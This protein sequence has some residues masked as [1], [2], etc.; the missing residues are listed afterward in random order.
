[1]RSSS[2]LVLSLLCVTMTVKAQFHNIKN[3]VFWNTKDNRPINSQG[4]GIFKFVDPVSG[5]Q[6]YYWYGVYYE[7][8][9]I[10]R[11]DP[12]ITLSKCTF[13]SVTCYSSVDLV[14][15]TFEADAV[16]KDEV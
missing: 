10:Y 4:G 13:K 16:K 2:F 1:M 6:K 8:A 3:D 7:E 14:N 5:I 11:N 9:D 15:W 12:T